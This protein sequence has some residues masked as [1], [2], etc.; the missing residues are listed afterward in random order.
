MK[1]LYTARPPYC[2]LHNIF[3][4][5]FSH[6]CRRIQYEPNQ[7]LCLLGILA[8]LNAFIAS[9]LPQ[10]SLVSLSANRIVT[11]SRRTILC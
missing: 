3:L 10:V 7:A 8:T 5:F 4:G 11:S 2:Y 1:T 6:E 9:I